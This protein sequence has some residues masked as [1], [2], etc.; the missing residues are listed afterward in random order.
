MEA[1]QRV[2][3]SA[4]TGDLDF[5]LHQSIELVREAKCD[6]GCSALHWA[7]GTNQI[8]IVKFLLDGCRPPTKQR[9]SSTYK[10]TPTSSLCGSIGDNEDL[11]KDDHIAIIIFQNV[12]I[13]VE[14]KLAKGRTPLHYAARN[15]HLEMVKL[16]V[17][18]YCADPFA[19]AKQG[20]TPFQLAVWQNRFDVC[21][22]LV[23]NKGVNI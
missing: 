16:L 7:A 13:L 23:K 1:H 4:K 20:V 17:E 15:G 5:L 22:Y 19:E 2:I 12:N 21:Q 18:K 11:H 14:S 10:S 6:V 3:H 9:S 8:Q